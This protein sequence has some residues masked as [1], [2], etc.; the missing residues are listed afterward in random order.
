MAAIHLVVHCFGAGYQMNI[1]IQFSNLSYQ[2]SWES[3]LEMM[4]MVAITVATPIMII[5]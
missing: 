3:I 4:M 1:K 5:L 2:K